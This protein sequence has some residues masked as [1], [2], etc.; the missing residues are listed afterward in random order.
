M[1]AP[2]TPVM[3]A[4]DLRVVRGGR[5]L[6]HVERFEVRSGL[7]HVLLGPNGAGK[8]TLLKALNGLEQADGTLEFEGRPVRGAAARLALRR[9]TAAVAQKPYLLSTSVLNNVASGLRY[10]GV[11]RREAHTAAREALELLGV[12]HLAD[13]KPAR[14]SGGEAQRVSIARALACDPMVLFLDEPIAALDPPTRRSLVDD[15]MRILDQRG[16]AAVWVTHDRDEAL[17]VGDSVTFIETGEVVQSGPALEVFSRPATESFATFLG[18]DTYLEGTVVVGR[19]GALRFILDAGHELSC[20]EAPLGHAVA[21]IPPEDVVLLTTAPEHNMSLRNILQGTVREVRPDGRLLRVIVAADGLDVA[22]LV[23]KAAFEEL[24]LAIG[25]PV[26]A[27]F[28]AAA[29]HPIPRH[30]RLNRVP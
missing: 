20:G 16:I 6:V 17:A 3:V 7:V 11:Q 27:A 21:C 25:S 28:K 14:L 15:L 23:T 8:S 12:P 13:R 1:S 2:A 5:T 30:E 9:R 22:A 26:A 10:R 29:L 18:L 4:R 24:A 19:E